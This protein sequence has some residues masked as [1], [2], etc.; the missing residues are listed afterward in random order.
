MLVNLP[1]RI[2]IRCLMIVGPTIKRLFS[3]AGYEIRRIS[4]V[5]H[6]DTSGAY[7][8]SRGTVEVT[9]FAWARTNQLLDYIERQVYTRWDLDAKN[10]NVP[11]TLLEKSKWGLKGF[12]YSLVVE[13]VKKLHSDGKDTL[14][15]LDVG[16]GG[17]GLPIVICEEFSDHCWLVDDFGI[18][19]SDKA[20][21]SWYAKG[22]RESLAAKNPMIHYVF[23]RL[24][25]GRIPELSGNSFDLIY[26]VSTLEHIPMVEMASVF[27]HMFDVLGP[28]GYMVHA[29]DITKLQL[30][31]WQI[32]LANYFKEYGVEPAVF[33][34]RNLDE[35]S[36]EDPP[37]LESV[38]VEYLLQRQRKFSRIGTLVLAIH[39]FHG[40]A[41]S[42]HPAG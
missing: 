20:T 28:N 4:P 31:E 15:V 22:L 21:A 23:G 13:T 41:A 32:F 33:A 3:M 34:I 19:S 27:D 10:Y 17:S 25:G 36:D 29:I 6:P 37:L 14:R 39:R 26:S 1:R 2:V 12:G 24:G 40:S 8:T 35:I 42:S 7:V 38:E 30:S 5:F 9:S 11:T 16:G 18:E